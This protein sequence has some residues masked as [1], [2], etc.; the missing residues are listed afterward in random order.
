MAIRKTLIKLGLTGGIASG[1]STVAAQWRD[2]GAAVIDADELAHQTLRPETPTHLAIVKTFGNK[3]INEDGT[4]NR[5]RLGVIVFANEQKRLALNQIVHPAV[6]QMWHEA[7]G[8]IERS[9]QADV[10]VLSIPL[11][12]EV[13]VENEF[14]RVVV[15][16]SSEQTQL[17]RLAAKGLHTTQARARVQAQWPIQK[18]MDKAD[19]VIW[20]DGSLAVLTEQADIIWA[21][22]KESHHA[23]GKN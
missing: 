23:P 21:T 16:A 19:F 1:K 12:Y 3:I 14:D 9:G 20:N 11:L 8:E 7:L 6:D 18:K 15:V 2:A 22:I 13:G 4:I 5:G 10:V 17:A